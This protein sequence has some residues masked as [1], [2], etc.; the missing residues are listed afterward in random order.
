M[1][2]LTILVLVV[3]AAT[4]HAEEIVI[5]QKGQWE[6]WTIPQG[7]IDLR[8]DGS[9]AMK[10]F[11]E[12][13]DP[14]QDMTEF[15]HK[16]RTRGVVSG[17]IRSGTDAGSVQFLTDGDE[18]TWW[19]PDPEDGLDNWWLDI[20]LGR[21][22]L[23][24]NI[25]MV[26]PDTPEDRPFRR[27]SVYVSEGMPIWDG[28]DLITFDRVATTILANE[29]PVLEISLL[30][31]DPISGGNQAIGDN[32][33]TADDL[34]F[35]PVQYI[36]FVAD[37]I[38]EGAAIAEIEAVAVGDNIALGTF[39][40][41]GSIRSSE[42]FQRT[43]PD[44]FDGSV[45]KFWLANAAKAAER[46]WKVGGQYFEWDLGV[47]FW[48]NQI[49]MYAWPP[50]AL[51]QTSFQASS[52]PKGHEIE[53]SDGTRINFGEGAERFRG[54]FDYERITLVDNRATPPRWIFQHPFERRKTRFIFYHHYNW[55]GTGGWGFKVWETFLY[56]PGHPAEVELT[57][58]MI[59]LDGVK[60]FR[61]VNW[62][63]D[64]PPG[65]GIQVRTKTGDKISV[66][67]LYYD[68]KGAEVTAER[69]NSL[70]KVLRGPTEEIP[71]EGDDW[72]SW[73]EPYKVSGEAF[74]SPNPRQYVRF[75]V[76]LTT[77]D[78][79]VTPV[80]KV[81]RVAYDEPLF[82]RAVQAEIFPRE[83]SVGAWEQFSYRILQPEFKSG[84]RGFDG[85][86]IPISGEVREV[87]LAIAGSPVAGVASE[88]SDDTLRIELPER[89][90]RDSVDIEFSA[91]LLQNP[92][93]IEAFL[94]NS[95]QPGRRQK[96]TPA[97]RVGGDAL[98]VFLPDLATSDNVISNVSIGAGS[99]TPNGDGVNDELLLTFDLIKVDAAPKVQF[100]DLQGRLVGEFAGQT[101]N[102]QEYRWSA[103]GIDGSTV[104]PGI[105][106]CRIEV[107]TAAG[108]HT[109]TEVVHVVY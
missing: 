24:K 63:A 99:V 81:L 68:R 69:W 21:L 105:Y 55:G 67:T 77:D 32:M 42:K 49:V 76:A 36:R 57:S 14:L 6:T 80:L 72:S 11:G 25:R 39:G 98:M 61:T 87:S 88:F 90:L 101:G 73:S 95:T 103:V 47:S 50:T 75:K 71:T 85:V 106:L 2:V 46:E 52:G 37:E 35:K 65:A 84:D 17:G 12:E 3:A 74:K 4:A 19:Q 27:F 79:A 16:T 92:T 41:G 48:L 15:E 38:N 60:N 83:S 107:D 100:F 28:R 45:E 33:V 7:V 40:R 70:K 58:E 104:P 102:V 56:A 89:V 13:I 108:V 53:V 91:R 5:D 51:G 30:T 43:A 94:V 78:P 34:D 22:V 54:P 18:G 8:A 93:F 109:A 23:L 26:F 29:D 64:L 66:K 62:E 82:Q 44:M 10:R 9:M 59:L 1:R 20:D 96:V 31:R 97:E 86:L